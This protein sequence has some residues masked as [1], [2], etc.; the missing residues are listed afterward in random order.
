MP[1]DAA[2]RGWDVRLMRR[3]RSGRLRFEPDRKAR[4]MRIPPFETQRS[5][6]R[7]R[8]VIVWMGADSQVAARQREGLDLAGL[9][10][11]M[12]DAAAAKCGLG[13]QVAQIHS[14]QSELELGQAAQGCIADEVAFRLGNESMDPGVY[15]ENIPAK[16]ICRYRRRVAMVAGQLFDHLDEA[17]RICRAG[18][19]DSSEIGF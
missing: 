3:A 8:A 5:V 9:D 6:E 14:A 10:K 17:F 4:R 16:I 12:P 18:A 7:L 2:V 15:A 13:E 19:P 11:A 1:G